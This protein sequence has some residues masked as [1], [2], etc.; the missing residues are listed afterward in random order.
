MFPLLSACDSSIAPCQVLKTRRQVPTACGKT[1]KLERR[2]S[3]FRT[4][5]SFF[6]SSVQR[7]KKEREAPR[8]KVQPNLQGA[9][10]RMSG[11]G[12]GTCKRQNSTGLNFSLV[13]VKHLVIPT[14]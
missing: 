9:A 11:R 14:L 13:K 1:E 8:G 4:P 2:V 3:E 7:D 6:F 5:E 12:N 10:K